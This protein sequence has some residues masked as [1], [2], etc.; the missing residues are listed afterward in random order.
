M[1]HLLL[2]LLALL[3]AS[4]AFAGDCADASAP[5][6]PCYPADLIAIDLPATKD[7]QTAYDDGDLGDDT[8]TALE[9][10]TNTTADMVVG[11]GATLNY[12][13]TGDIT[14]LRATTAGAFDGYDT[15][16][17]FNMYVTAG[18]IAF[19]PTANLF[20]TSAIKTTA[21]GSDYNGDVFVAGAFCRRS[22]ASGMACEGDSKLAFEPTQD[23]WFDDEDLDSFW[24]A[25]EPAIMMMS[26]NTTF[27]FWWYDTDGDG[28]A[29]SGEPILTGQP[30][31]NDWT[32]THKV[33]L[34]A[35]TANFTLATTF[36]SDVSGTIFTNDGASGDIVLTIPDAEAGMR[37]YVAIA[38]AHYVDIEPDGTDMI[39]R[40]TS[41]G[42][43]KLGST[44]VG[45][46]VELIAISTT[47]WVAFEH[48]T[49][50]DRGP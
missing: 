21:A 16:L 34:F 24:T 6:P 40:L 10:G 49:W 1:T 5:G 43:D 32:L 50:E 15:E 41:D 25:D 31:W 33:P 23:F 19:A 8:F 48:G 20:P 37:F 45:D 42:G 27:S 44:V 17:P 30:Q 26:Y 11:S 3:I 47:E 22:A 46:T 2:I 18:N 35:K 4:P 14:A 28:N 13:G 12:S 38:E 36:G 39:L 29:E 9:S 7:L